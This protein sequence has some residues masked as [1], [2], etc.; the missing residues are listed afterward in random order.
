MPLSLTGDRVRLRPLELRDLDTIWFAYQDLDLAL[1]TDGDAPPLSDHQV[2]ALWTE[3]ITEPGPDLRYFAIE[4]LPG[5]PGAGEFAGACSL[6]HIDMRNRRAELGIFMAGREIRGQGYGTDAV[7]LLLNYAFEVILLDKVYLGVYDFNEAGLRA[8]ERAGFRYEGRLRHMIYYDD[9]WWDEWPMGVL[10]TEWE[11]HRKPPA[12]GLRHYHPADEPAALALIQQH[13]VAPDVN[14]ARS[15]LRRW[16]RQIDRAVYCYQE[17]GTLLAVFTL[18][19]TTTP[20]ALLDAACA[21][22][23][24]PRLD[25][26]LQA[27]INRSR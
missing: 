25:A 19:T 12:D 24:R 9:Q 6:Q 16:W 13:L 17:S 18:D 23:D 15:T 26:A 3:I 20:P 7:R 21:P 8:Y 27:L 10:R 2:R 14:A 22:A 5:Q 4:P 11:Q 1:I